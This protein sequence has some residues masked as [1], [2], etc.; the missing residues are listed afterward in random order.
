MRTDAFE[1]TDSDLLPLGPSGSQGKPPAKSFHTEDAGF[2]S[3]RMAAL[4]RIIHEGFVHNP[5]LPDEQPFP[6]TA[7]GDGVAGGPGTHPPGWVR[8]NH[9]PAT[10]DPFRTAAPKGSN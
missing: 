1:H 2:S 3:T 7:G 10:S 6:C 9:P 4:A 8:F 5:S